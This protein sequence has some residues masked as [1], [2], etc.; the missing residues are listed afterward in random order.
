VVLSLNGGLT[1]NGRDVIVRVLPT[2]YTPSAPL[3]RQVN[4][5]VARSW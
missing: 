2:P 4:A 1:L 5:S 3:D